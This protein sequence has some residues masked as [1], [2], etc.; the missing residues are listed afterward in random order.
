I[1]AAL[2]AL[3]EGNV[4]GLAPEGTRSKVTHALQEGKTGAAFLALATGATVLPVGLTGTERI[5]RALRRLRSAPVRVCIG[6][7]LQLAARGENGRKGRRPQVQAVTDE[8]MCQIAALLPEEY[9][10]VYAGHPRL[11]E[12]L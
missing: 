11:L 12:L 1:K 3:Q 6:K 9:R 5:G 7:P 2:L 4:L 10:G 8:I